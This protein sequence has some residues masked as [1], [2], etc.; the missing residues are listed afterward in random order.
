ML[1]TQP[2]PVCCC[3]C[4]LASGLQVMR[5]YRDANQEAAV[6]ASLMDA[7]SAR[8][9]GSSAVP[10]E[11]HWEQGNLEDWQRQAAFT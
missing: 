3:F 1:A 2:D 11:L 8:P 9:L 5:V 7:G 4:V 10:W 6:A